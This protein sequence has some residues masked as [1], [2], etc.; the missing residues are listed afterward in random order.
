MPVSIGR[1]RERSLHAALKQRYARPGDQFE[2]RVG[3]YVIDI[4]RGDPDVP[5]LIEVQTGSFAKI[6]PK[7]LALCIRF[8]WCTRSP[9]RS[10][11]CASTARTAT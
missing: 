4:V 2:T 1:L 10:G 5:L 3:G 7:L 9:M 8:G 11:S 6:K